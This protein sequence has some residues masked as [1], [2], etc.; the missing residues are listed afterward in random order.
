[1]NFLAHIYLSGDSDEV[2]IG[3][4]IADF[5][6]MD[7]SGYSAEILSGITLHRLIDTYTDNHP[8]VQESK[9]RLYPK[10]HKY[11]T[12]IVDVFYDHFLAKN[13]GRYYIQESLQNYSLNFYSML[14]DNWNLL[15]ERVKQM[16]PYMEKE[17][18]LLAY[19]SIDGVNSALTGLSR[20]ARF[21]SGMEAASKDLK[22]NY[23]LFEQEF[24]SFFQDLKEFSAKY[25]SANFKQ[26]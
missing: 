10:Y 2:K 5:V 12:V 25:L 23:E 3:N 8:V 20:R 9:T 4:F 11:A 22:L 15:P 17:N 24:I 16:L 21:S 1:M 6:K 18:W 7:I 13:W 19:S 26:Q 14:R